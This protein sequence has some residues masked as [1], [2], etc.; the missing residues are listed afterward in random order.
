MYCVVFLDA[1]IMIETKYLVDSHILW[2]TWSLNW[3]LI[4]FDDIEIW[5]DVNTSECLVLNTPLDV[6]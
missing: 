5:G 1:F 2:A 6:I 4:T 3:V